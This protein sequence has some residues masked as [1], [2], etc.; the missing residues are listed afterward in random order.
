MSDKFYFIRLVALVEL[1]ATF[2]AMSR[3]SDPKQL[4]PLAPATLTGLCA[5]ELALGAAE[6]GGSFTGDG[7]EAAGQVALIA[8][9]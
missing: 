5:G 9:A 8:E 4:H 3:L 1:Y 2:Y 6:G 7:A